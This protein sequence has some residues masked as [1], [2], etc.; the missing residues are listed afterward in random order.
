MVYL[1]RCASSLWSAGVGLML[2]VGDALAFLWWLVV[3][4]LG[5][6]GR[7]RLGGRRRLLASAFSEIAGL[8]GDLSFSVRMLL[9]LIGQ[10]DLRGCLHQ[11]ER[12]WLQATSAWT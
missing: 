4:L 10:I 3:V 11:L 5:F 8:G 7:G 1:S 6:L 2:A 9:A 12:A